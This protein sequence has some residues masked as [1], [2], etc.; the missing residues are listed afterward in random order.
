VTRSDYFALPGVNW[1]LLKHMGDS[2]LAYRHALENGTPDTD[3]LALGRITHALV[4]EP[5]T[6]QHD[7]AIWTGGRRAGKEWEAFAE[8]HAHQ[9]ILRDED[10]IE[11]HDMAEAVKRHPLV[12]GY[13]AG[14]EFERGL[15]WTD[16]RTGLPCK[17]RP[18][19]LLSRR[20]I[21]L[22]LKTAASIEGR[23]FGAAAARYGYHCQLAHY[24]A[25]VRAALG[26]E[27]AAVKL[28]V[29]EK[30]PPH[31]VAVF[32]VGPEDLELGADEV[33]ALLQRLRECKDTDTWPG[34]YTGEQA[35]A[36]PAYIH[37][38]LE[39]EYE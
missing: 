33:R 14:G 4:F 24:A 2:P 39:F 5:E 29:V 27:P 38:E 32:D 21:L 37:G 8:R 20:R 35:L 16:E 23:R 15:Q 36:L 17:A 22:D 31:D 30:R 11:A 3:A 6:F 13:L 9:T 28:V 1:S 7:Y 10:V 19:W 26:W 18:D 34:R 12:R 25:G